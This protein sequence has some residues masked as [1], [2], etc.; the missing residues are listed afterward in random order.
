METERRT[1]IT[2]WGSRPP[3]P[4]IHLTRGDGLKTGARLNLSRSSSGRSAFSITKVKDG[5]A[6]LGSLNDMFFFV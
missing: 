5:N 1:S 6:N 2:T 3:Y 4:G